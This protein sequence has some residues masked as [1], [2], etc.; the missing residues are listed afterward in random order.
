MVQSLQLTIKSSVFDKSKILNID[1]EFIELGTKS[2]TKFEIAELRYGVEA[3][4]GYRFNIGRSYC[5]EIRSVTGT[6]MKIRLRSL[7]GIKKKKLGQQYLLILNTILKFYIDDI[8]KSF[9]TKFNNKITFSILGVTFT[10]Q[11]ILIEKNVDLIDWQ[12]L[13][14][15]NYWSYYSLFSKTNPDKHKIFKYLTDWNTIVVEKLSKHI[16][17]EKNLL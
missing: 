1:P 4:R 16:L 9:Y 10:Q 15:K 7:Y 12:D 5:I 17:R 6:V 3:I 13:G 2:L 14:V 8:C 11:G